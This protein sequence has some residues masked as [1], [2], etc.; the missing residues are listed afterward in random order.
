MEAEREVLALEP[1]AD[2]PEVGRWLSAMEDARRDTLRELEGLAHEALDWRPIGGQNT[3]GTLLYH[4]ALVEADWLLTDILGPDGA[5]LWPRDLLPFDDRDADDRLTQVAG[6]TLERHLERLRAVR[7]LFLEQMRPMPVE[8]F[9][10]L[11]TRE[12]F[13]VAADWVVH[14]LLQHE[15]EHRA[16]VAALRDARAQA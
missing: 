10:R 13:D 8:D 11:R 12:R 1:I 4:I 6:E 15:A 2:D 14:H 7:S 16:Q 9:H 5:R 3:I